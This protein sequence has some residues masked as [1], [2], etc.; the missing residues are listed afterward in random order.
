MTE[1]AEIPPHEGESD[2]VTRLAYGDRE[3]LLVG[4]A[5]VSKKSVDEVRDVI[6][7][8]RPDTVCVELDA[9]RYETLT[10][11]SRFSRL[12]VSQIV[13]AGRAGLFLSSLLF[14][15]FQKRLGD[16]VGVRPG[17]EMLAAV[18]AAKSIGA[19]I[20]LA[21][22]DIQATLTRCY[23]SLGP[24]D[25]VK[26][27]AAL[28]TLPF[29]AAEIDEAQIEQ[30]K[31]RRAIGDAMEAF[32]RQMPSLKRPLIDERDQFLMSSTR[33]APGRRIVAIVGAAHVAGM[34]AQLD[35][36]IDRD[37]LTTVPRRRRGPL[38]VGG[39]MPL[40]AVAIVAMTFAPARHGFDTG[41]ILR[42]LLVPPVIG[43][44][45][46]TWIAGG[47][48]SA[49]AAA[50]LAPAALFA[51]SQWY[52]RAIGGIQARLRPPRPEDAASVRDD[53]LHPAQFRRNP[54]LVALLTGVF[55]RLGRT[56]GGTIGVI[57]ALTRLF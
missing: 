3:I 18:D 46:F 29:A 25:R 23:A 17:S 41:A 43:A 26:V 48:F 21:D 9:A 22:R 36:P 34:A 42:R 16:R 24:L 7:R 37:A 51:P 47:T 35:T 54:F 53:V 31:Q 55:A 49:I 33:E 5:H 39:L 57:L 6:E 40:F 19:R 13:R 44:A 11:E 32:A 28:A 27:I 2:N 4:T 15:A 1:P 30:L 45:L 38:L 50:L 52:G 12:D 8:L 14:S 56:I 20:V 10:D